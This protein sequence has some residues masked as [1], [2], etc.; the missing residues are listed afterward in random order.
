MLAVFQSTTPWATV[1][2]RKA[3]GVA[4]AAHQNS[5]RYGMRMA[6]PSGDWGSLPVEGGIEAAYR[7]EIEAAA[8]PGA[9]L[10]AIEARLERLRS[11]F[12]AGERFMP[13]EIIDPRK[14][15]P[16]L[17]EF[18]DMAAPCRTAGKTSFGIRP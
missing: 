5:A 9:H 15:R 1:I 14:T 17:C 10:Q 13:E 7:A 8:D 2:V 6:W 11:P 3:F 18:A 12:R 16:L 4:G